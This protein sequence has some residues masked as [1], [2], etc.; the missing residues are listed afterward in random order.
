MGGILNAKT[1]PHLRCKAVAGGANNQL[2]NI[3]D[4]QLLFKRGILYAPDF[5]INAGGVINAAM[6]FEPG[7]YNPVTSR[8]K[9]DN[10]YDTLQLV[11]TKSKLEKKPTHQVAEELADYNLQHGLSRRKIPI[12]FERLLEI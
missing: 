12:D 9:V 8:E 7:G 3:E 2:L 5:I 1:I 6:E 10:I 4:G 11:F